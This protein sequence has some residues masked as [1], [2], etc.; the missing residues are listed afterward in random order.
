MKG[1]ITEVDPWIG[2]RVVRQPIGPRI[3]GPRS[4]I[5]IKTL[6]RSQASPKKFRMPRKPARGSGKEPVLLPRTHSESG[7]NRAYAE[8]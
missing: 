2:A 4:K 8:V 6:P 1:I 3:T 7:G 5:L